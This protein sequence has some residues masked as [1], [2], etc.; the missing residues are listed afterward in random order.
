[1]CGVWLESFLCV[2]QAWSDKINNLFLLTVSSTDTIAPTA[3]SFATALSEGQ[4]AAITAVVPYP[5]A[6]SSY[7]VQVRLAHD[8][9]LCHTPFPQGAIKM[10]HVYGCHRRFAWK[11]P[12]YVALLFL[13]PRRC[14]P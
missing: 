7:F 11:S 6:P 8:R 13:R 4:N 1:M 10:V 3:G 12:K 2:A 14:M 5:S 9:H